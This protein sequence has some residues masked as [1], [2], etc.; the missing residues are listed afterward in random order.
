MI[1]IDVDHPT[2]IEFQVF[3]GDD[4]DT[5][6][7]AAFSLSGTPIGHFEAATFVTEPRRGGTA[8]VTAVIDGETITT[9]VLVRVRSV[10]IAGGAPADAEARFGAAVDQPF[11]AHQTPGPLAVVPPNLGAFQVDFVASDADDLHELAITSSY[12][13]LRVYA[14][15][16]AGSRQIVL[17]DVE[18]D[19]MMQTSRGG[20][21]D[22]GIRSMTEAEPATVRA[23][24][25]HVAVADLDAVGS[26]LVPATA[27]METPQLWS[28]DLATAIQSR[29]ASG[30][31]GGC[32]GCHMSVSRDGTRIAA[33]GPTND[34]QSPMLIDRATR[35]PVT[36]NT[37]DPWSTGDFDGAGHLITDS[38]DGA[39]AVRNQSTGDRL[40]TLPVAGVAMF[41]AV[42]SDGTA[43]A[44]GAATT[45]LGA[46][47]YELRVHSWDA[48]TLGPAR[49]LVTG[50]TGIKVPQF[51]PDGAWLAYARTTLTNSADP[52]NKAD[53]LAIVPTSGSLP[54]HVLST[55][56]DDRFL[57]WL[58]TFAPARADGRDIA[59]MIWVV[60]ASRRSIGVPLAPIAGPLP[61]TTLWL[62]AF[63]PALG[64]I[65][66]PFPL[67]GQR[68]D[69]TILHRP[70][71]L[72][73]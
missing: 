72:P 34:G 61:P 44:Y 45:D 4:G 35:Y 41:P 16:V 23:S 62:A 14:P 21:A 8:I 19:A 36:V 7:R 43:I 48:T 60:I 66:E 51:S 70:Q 63:D 18:R 73:P 52:A 12:L 39:L 31:G 11:D 9:G 27:A 13:D 17:D 26:L 64:M 28:Y 3:D 46:L 67:P 49:V 24:V 42:A 69:V 15:G 29:W 25:A 57:T 55:N 71:V 47:P 32:I 5:T 38:A 59:S 2:S 68:R 65:S 54:A 50:T 1:T 30:A 40:R 53:G 37:A 33:G 20:G 56:P 22:V 58:G 10:R 6:A